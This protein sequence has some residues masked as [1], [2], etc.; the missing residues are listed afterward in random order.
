MFAFLLPHWFAHPLSGLGYQFFSGIG[1]S[2][3]EWLT[4]LLAI[5][6]YVY[7]HNCHEHRCVRLSWHPDA[8]GHPICKKHHVRPPIPRLAPNHSLSPSPFRAQAQGTKQMR[9]SHVFG[10]RS[11]PVCSTVA[12]EGQMRGGFCPS[13]FTAKGGYQWRRLILISQSSYS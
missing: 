13:L 1:S 3:S 2:I 7:H 5:G 10:L 9:T 8:E 11:T 6:V 4:I 12:C